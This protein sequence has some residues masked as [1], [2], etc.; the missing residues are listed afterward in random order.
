MPTNVNV[1]RLALQKTRVTEL[2]W[3]Q[4]PDPPPGIMKF[5]GMVEW[6]AQMKRVRETDREQIQSMLLN[7]PD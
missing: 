2:H 7:Q 4:W 1:E 6:W 3:A 5:P